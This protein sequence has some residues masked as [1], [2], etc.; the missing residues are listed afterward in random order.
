MATFIESASSVLVIV[1]IAI[2]V[3]SLVIALVCILQLR[4]LKRPFKGMSEVYAKRGGE[5]ALEE[6][7]K[8]VDEN[9]EFLRG[10]SDELKRLHGLLAQCYSGLG[11]VKYNAF[12]DI[13]GMQSYSLC[14]LT[15]EKN[16]CIL[17]NLVGRTATR[18]YALEVKDAK[19]S[20]QLSD[21]EKESL[22]L[23]LRMLSPSER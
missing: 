11:L 21:E 23:A 17:T 22:E 20:R 7:L 8:G 2:A 3:L 13:G 4:T 6:L 18:G 15:R 9:R 16:G 14:L 19:P 10:H 1:S 12:E 5:G